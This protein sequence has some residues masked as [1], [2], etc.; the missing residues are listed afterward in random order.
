MSSREQVVVHPTAE[1]S[2]GCPKCGREVETSDQACPACGLLR[3][4]FAS[5][6]LAS[7]QNGRLTFQTRWTFVDQNWSDAEAHEAFLA[8]AQREAALAAAARWYRKA[9]R[10]RRGDPMAA[11]QLER[12]SRMALAVHQVTAAPVPRER[13]TSRYRGLVM[14]FVILA[15][16][17]FGLVRARGAGSPPRAASPG[18][19]ASPRPPRYTPVLQSGHAASRSARASTKGA[20]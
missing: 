2:G 19:I 1:G 15:L 18:E 14:L 16:G 8:A 11:R 20:P 10:K 5:F 9:A 7:R 3:A 6:R 17:G 12:I 13:S 4:H